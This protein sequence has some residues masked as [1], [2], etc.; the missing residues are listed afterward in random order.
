MYESSLILL[1]MGM[2]TTFVFLYVMI[3]CTNLSS[4][5]VPKLAK[6][7]PD[8]EPKKAKPA[9]KPATAAADDE[10]IVAA[11]AAAMVKANA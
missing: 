9:A 6:F 11:I 1:V 4:K 2:G 5:F 3:L 10:A 7:L 8:P